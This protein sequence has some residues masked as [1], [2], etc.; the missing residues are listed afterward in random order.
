[1]EWIEFEGEWIASGNSIWIISASSE[2]SV[3]LERARGH[4]LSH[5][6]DSGRG[7]V[8]MI[9]FFREDGTSPGNVE[10]A[11]SMAEMLESENERFSAKVEEADEN[12]P[13]AETQEKF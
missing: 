11:K 6:I 12:K 4:G 5:L 1:M 10:R 9:G 7:S 3:K 8:S 2:C 13:I